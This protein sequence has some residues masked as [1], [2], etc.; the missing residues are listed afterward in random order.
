MQAVLSQLQSL[1]RDLGPHLGTTSIRQAFTSSFLTVCARLPETTE[2]IEENELGY[3]TKF[4]V[5]GSA[6]TRVQQPERSEPNE[7]ASANN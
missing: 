1:G 2:F 7:L 6:R 3:S 4:V 5:L